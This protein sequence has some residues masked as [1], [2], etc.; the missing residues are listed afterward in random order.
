[1]ASQIFTGAR[2]K[3]LLG[4]DELGDITGWTFRVDVELQRHKPIGKLQSGEIV[5]VDQTVSGTLDTVRIVNNPVTKRQLFGTRAD[6][7]A[8]GTEYTIH[9]VDEVTDVVLHTL[10]GVKFGSHEFRMD[11][12]VIVAESM[13]FEAIT[14][15]DEFTSLTT[16]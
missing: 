13:A 15:D 10:T 9:L 14:E 1:M 16:P 8:G 5:P 7:Q 3:L 4:T 6:L 2:G 11:G 12:K